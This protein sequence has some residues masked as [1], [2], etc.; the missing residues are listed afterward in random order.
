MSKGYTIQFYIKLIRKLSN[1]AILENIYDAIA[2]VGGYESVKAYKL[3]EWL[4]D[5]NSDNTLEIIFG[6]TDRALAFGKT[7]KTRLIK[8]L[9]A[10]K[11]NGRVW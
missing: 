6:T 1:N 9:K 4:G 7:P 2:P 3:D 5:V 10:R 11:T 8:A